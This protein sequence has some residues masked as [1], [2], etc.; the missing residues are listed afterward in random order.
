MTGPPP[1]P[2]AWTPP[3]APPPVGPAPGLVYAGFLVR[4]GAFIVDACVLAIA[5]FAILAPLGVPLGQV[6]AVDMAFGR[7]WRL[8]LDP[9][10]GTLNTLLSLAYFVGFWSWRGQTVGMMLFGLRLVRA[11]DG[12]RVDP[13]T[14][15]IRYFMLLISFAVLFLGVIAVGLD[16]HKQGWHDKLVRTVVVRPA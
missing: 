6:H 14:A 4:T 9:T 10:A 7:T 15:A 12:G 1:P 3:P 8:E 16:R 11:E 2:A 5:V 13:V